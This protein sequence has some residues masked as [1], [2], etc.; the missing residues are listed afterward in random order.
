MMKSTLLTIA[1]YHYIYREL[2]L[3]PSADVCIQGFIEEV[4]KG[5]I[6]YAANEIVLFAT[7]R[8]LG[9][10]N[11]A[12]YQWTCTCAIC[13]SVDVAISRYIGWALDL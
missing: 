13:E 5:P 10:L 7:V 1:M 2:W 9:L 11:S 12:G 8:L 6:V 4:G 3:A